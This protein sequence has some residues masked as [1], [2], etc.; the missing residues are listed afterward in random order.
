MNITYPTY[1]TIIPANVRHD[2]NLP[3]GAKLL[4]GEF[5]PL[6]DKN[7]QCLTTNNYF[8]KLYNV[9]PATISKWISLLKKGGYIHVKMKYIIGTIGLEARCISLI[10]PGGKK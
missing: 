7:G 6:L 1:Y 10:N 2:R 9:T 5:T 8:A 4:Y 3:P